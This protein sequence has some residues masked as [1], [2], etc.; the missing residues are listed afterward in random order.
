M[1]QHAEHN[2]RVNTVALIV[3]TASTGVLGLAFWA[4]AARL[5]PAHE[6]G[7]ASALI[8]SAVLLST[9]STLGL[10][11]LYE[12]FLPV[13][14][15]RAPVL[16]HRGFL[17][18]AGMGVLTGSVLVAVGPRDPLFQS[19][20]AMAGFPLMVLVL[21]VFA[22]LDKAAAGLG[23]ARWSAAKNLAHA[24]AKLAAVAALA[25][26]DEAATIVLSW[27]L[28]AAVAAL[29]TYVVLHRRSR[30]HPRWQ[31]PANLPPRRQMWSYFG[32]SFGIASLWSIGPLVVP[33]I[34]ITQ[35][36]PAANAY[37]AV[38]WAMISALYLMLHLVVSPYVAEVAAHPDQVHA[39]S[40]RMVRML[41]AVAA[42][43]SVGL[44][45]AGP[46]LLSLAGDEY[47]AEGTD[48]LWLAAAFLPLSAVGAAYEGFAR[49]QRRLALYLTVQ[50]LVTTVIITGSWMG[51][52]ALG[53][54]GVGW[55][56]LVAE[57]LSA[58]ILIGPAVAWLRRA[59]TGP[60]TRPRHTAPT[61]RSWTRVGAV[62]LA[63]MLPA[64]L[65]YAV[66][67][68][69]AAAS[70]VLF[71]DFN[72]PAGTPPD[73]ARWGHDVGGGGW[74]NGESQVYTDSPKNAALDGNGHLVITARRDGNRITSARLTTQHRLSFV[75]G[76]AE[77]RLRLPRGAGLHPAF[78]LLGTDLDTVGWPRS[79]ELD[80]VETI[81]DAHFLHTGAIGPD[82]DGAEYKLSGSVPIDPSFVDGFHTYWVQ[83]EPGIVSMGVDDRTTTVF[84]AADLPAEQQWVFDKPFF[85][86]LNVAVGGRWPGPADDSTP[87]PAV[88][89]VDWVRVTGD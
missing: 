21:A 30:S 28:T 6:V 86:L 58:A 71:D 55:A 2:L 51:T 45:V 65:L 4:V 82:L 69:T 5:F 78:W 32:S 1:N 7:L 34:V 9:M 15:T 38:C 13:T 42:L 36:G 20:W 12:R 75:H 50:T 25:I 76:R 33:L 17:V 66:E 18:V 79:G 8:T 81:G 39:L 41:A 88:M 23:V 84:H 62:V 64:V 43:A 83:R 46:F 89:T 68:P 48:L 29:C 60:G 63:A 27:T 26:W 87:F 37:F 10:D 22:L 74:G 70:L 54:T 14:G 67:R 59:G 53:V 47:R 3:S 11:V 73:P 52:R 61:G 31:Q 80:V 56:Y 49:V 85:L 35:V 24:V 19:G 57:A 72:G 40:W 44:V 16:L 77:A